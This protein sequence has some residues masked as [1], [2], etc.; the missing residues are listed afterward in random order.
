MAPVF[1]DVIL[2]CHYTIRANKAD[3]KANINRHEQEAGEA[4]AK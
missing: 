3:L 2:S 1:G 4:T